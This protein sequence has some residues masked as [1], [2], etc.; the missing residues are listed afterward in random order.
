MHMY[1]FIHI[2]IHIYIYN[3]AC[4]YIALSIERTCTDVRYDAGRIKVSLQHLLLC[5]HVAT[6]SYQNCPS[7]LSSGKETSREFNGFM[8]M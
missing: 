7:F 8:C 5:V 4:V 1:I 6:A 2:Y 3:Y